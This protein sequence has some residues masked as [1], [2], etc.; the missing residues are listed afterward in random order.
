M[1]GIV[2][3]LMAGGSGK[4]LWPLSRKSYPKQFAQLLNGDSLFQES[5]KRVTSSKSIEFLPPLIATN[6]DYRFIIAEQLNNLHIEPDAILIEPSMRNTA[7]AILAA[8]IF[9]YQRDPRAV[10]LITPSDHVIA[11]KE[12]FHDA[13]YRGTKELWK[14]KIVIF[15]VEPTRAETGYGY[16]ECSQQPYAEAVEV[17]RFIEK[18]DGELAQILFR[19]E[20]YLW[21]AGIFLC[22]AKDLL[23]AFQL[24][25][26]S[27]IKP[28]SESKSGHFPGLCGNG[29]CEKFSRYTL[30]S[31]MVG[32]G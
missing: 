16:L 7:P 4:L 2:P 14:N 3:I 5:A 22:T 13:I 18:P 11:D 31:W 10:L 28:T 8:T 27:L 1:K 6:S 17:S 29:T 12:A 24:Y 15:G 9:S 21:N 19:S 20:C 23:E 32:S 26:A 30:P 25:A